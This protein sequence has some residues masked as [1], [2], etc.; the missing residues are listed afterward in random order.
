MRTRWPEADQLEWYEAKRSV[1]S[2]SREWLLCKSD[3]AYWV[4]RYVQILNATDE[5]WRPFE[6]WPKQRDVLEA[7]RAQRQL[8]VLKARQLGL[9]WLALAFALHR[10]IFHPI[11]TIG[12]FSRIEADAQELLDIRLK[13]MY[14][15]LPESMKEQPVMQDNKTR[16]Q[17][18]NGSTAMAFA[19][20]GGRGY[21]FSL[22]IVD[23]ADF[24][25]DL[26]RLLTAVEPTVDMGGRMW[27]ISSSNKDIPESRFKA[28]YRV[29]Q[30][31]DKSSVD[32]YYP[33][34]LP[35]HARPGRTPEW[36]E[37]QKAKCLAET[38]ALD[39][40]GGE[41]PATDTEA[42][43]P[44]TLDKRIPAIW[45]EACYVAQRPSL[46][47]DAPVLP[48]LDVYVPPQAGRLYV[49]GA[50]S[51]EG[52]PTSDDSALSVMDV[53]SGEEVAQLSGKF[54][55]SA[56]ASY[57]DALGRY[58]NDAGLMVER[59]NHGHAVLLWLADNSKLRRLD[60]H[61]GK[62]GWLS[63]SLGKA[64]LYNEMADCFRD[65]DTTLHSFATYT[66]LAS[67]EGSALRAPEGFHDD[68]ADS[69]ALA[70]VGRIAMQTEKVAMKQALVSGRAGGPAIRKAVRS[71]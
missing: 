54:Q 59:N 41:Y 51:A 62:L 30:R 69:Y 63:S 58:Y 19:T 40:I 28:I 18:R 20:T 34:F 39:D 14:E 21:T 35:W 57:A 8:V 10:M 44:R 46:P 48:N 29:A 37:V 12:I 27:L 56:L 11:A 26:P 1:A 16:W 3:V 4:D 7:M 9:T 23:E 65:G 47:E 71:A 64:L 32:A 70:H 43:A 24:Q 53:E 22:A 2:R 60:G 5:R 25:P 17:L 45:I 61:D 33:I 13:G 36:Y 31:E 6:L 15:R 50:D 55:P 52:N 38:G 66:Q 42:L 67:I 49:I 68:R